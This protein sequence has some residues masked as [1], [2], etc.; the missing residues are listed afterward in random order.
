M[1]I[2]TQDTN[3]RSAGLLTAT[4][5]F[6]LS[7]STKSNFNLIISSRGSQ[8]DSPVR[9]ELSKRSK[10]NTIIGHK[11]VGWKSPLNPLTKPE[12]KPHSKQ[13]ASALSSIITIQHCPYPQSTIPSP[14]CD[15][16]AV[17]KLKRA[18]CFIPSFPSKA[19]KYGNATPS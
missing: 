4:V 10:M 7:A 9:L 5:F 18:P 3:A 17:S 14:S 19:A 11:R 16:A 1:P 15:A 13:H 8:S 6:R 2:H 12:H